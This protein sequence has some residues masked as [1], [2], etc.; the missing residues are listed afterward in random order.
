ML[1]IIK[2]V[3]YKAEEYLVLVT[4]LGMILIVAWSVICRGVL[5]VPF[6]IG[7]ELSRYLMIYSVFIGIAV[8]VRRGSHVGIRAFV[9][10]LPVRV[11]DAV[12]YIQRILTII[13]YISLTVVSL[14][15]SIHFGQIGQRSTMMHVPMSF[16]Y[17]ILPIGFALSA[18]HSVENLVALIKEKKSD[19]GKEGDQ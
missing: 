16:V 5:K 14:L 1:K 9:N 6:L 18:V 7:E 3:I 17:A 8:G 11:G 13:T 2:N 15:V 19:K 4:V 10:K 12:E